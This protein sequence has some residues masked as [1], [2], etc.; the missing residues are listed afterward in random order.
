MIS[1]YRDSDYS[2][3]NSLETL[4]KCCCHS[5]SRPF[6]HECCKYINE[7]GIRLHYAQP[8]Y[9]PKDNR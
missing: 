5:G 2:H 4:C 9:I 3:I 6:T 7:D 1:G 8:V